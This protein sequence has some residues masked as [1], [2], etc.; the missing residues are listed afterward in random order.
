MI[1]CLLDFIYNA[2]GVKVIY[3]SVIKHTYKIDKDPND[4]ILVI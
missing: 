2:A 4:I 1:I 3:L